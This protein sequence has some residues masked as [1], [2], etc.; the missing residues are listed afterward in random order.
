M[1]T[2]HLCFLS[3]VETLSATMTIMRDRIEP[4]IQNQMT[5]PHRV[6]FRQLKQLHNVLNK[7]ERAVEEKGPNG[8]KSCSKMETFLAPDQQ[9][10]SVCVKLSLDNAQYTKFQQS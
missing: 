5:V 4:L 1:S 10:R 9:L 3:L 7:L 8:E 2:I 6:R